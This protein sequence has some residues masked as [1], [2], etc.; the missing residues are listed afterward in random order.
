MP[1]YYKMSGEELDSSDEEG[2]RKLDE[3]AERKGKET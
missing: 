1:K 3:W 2:K